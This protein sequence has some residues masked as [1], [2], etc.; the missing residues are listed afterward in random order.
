MTM[1]LFDKLDDV[2]IKPTQALNERDQAA[3]AREE[4][5][6]R[7]LI[8]QTQRLEA[9][10]APLEKGGEWLDR[11]VES[12]RRKIRDAREE[13]ATDFVRRLINHFQ[14][15]YKIT[16]NHWELERLANERLREKDC[17]TTQPVVTSEEIVGYVLERLGGRSFYDVA[18]TELKTKFR[19]RL[20]G[21]AQPK[22]RIVRLE[23]FL[24]IEENYSGVPRLSYGSGEHWTLLQRAL[25]HFE[26]PSTTDTIY[27][28][29]QGLPSPYYHDHNPVGDYEFPHCKRINGATIY[30]NGNVAIKFPT[31]ELAIEFCR[32]YDLTTT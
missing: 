5:A 15:T 12:L 29:T 13:E 18:V 7:D 10:I 24:Y 14:S 17:D 6:Y 20:Y 9:A 3:I 16:L 1:S 19:Q 31:N 8:D 11:R 21:G 28:I 23:R 4:Q 25:S 32:T 27:Q 30:K 22:G 2:E 26:N